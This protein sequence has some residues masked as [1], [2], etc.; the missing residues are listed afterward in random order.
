MPRAWTSAHR[1]EVH[2]FARFLTSGD[3]ITPEF[4]LAPFPIQNFRL[5]SVFR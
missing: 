4:V 5:A 2:A 1:V 3:P